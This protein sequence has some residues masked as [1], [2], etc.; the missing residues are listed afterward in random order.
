MD[1]LFGFLSGAFLVNSIPHLANGISGKSHMTP[2]SKES[3][4][5]VN[6]V[7]AFVNIFIGVWLLNMSNRTIVDVY[8]MDAFSWSFYL[9]ALGMAI[10]CA[11]L[12]GKKDARFPWF[13]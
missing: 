13:K 11:W 12:F 1:L 4:A 5:I 6:V 10:A 2:F 7:W 3:S 8:T 9:G